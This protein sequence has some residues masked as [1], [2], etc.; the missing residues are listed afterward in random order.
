MLWSQP[1]FLRLRTLVNE[2]IKLADGEKIADPELLATPV[3]A[4]PMGKLTEVMHKV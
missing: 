3:V 1:S 2:R 4:H